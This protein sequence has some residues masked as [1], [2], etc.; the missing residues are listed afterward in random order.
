[1][2]SI[3]FTFEIAKPEFVMPTLSF[4]AII[5]ISLPLFFLVIGVQ[6]IQ[7]VGVLLAEDYKPPINAMYIVPSIAPS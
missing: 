2:K 3:P 6:N 5:D 4:K 7:A 1:M